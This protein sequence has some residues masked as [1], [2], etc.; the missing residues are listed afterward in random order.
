MRGDALGWGKAGEWRSERD[1]RKIG[2]LA[3]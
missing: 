3:E 2:K 1:V